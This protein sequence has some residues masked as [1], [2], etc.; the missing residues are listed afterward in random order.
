M[1]CKPNALVLFNPVFNNGPG[2]WGH[3]RAGGSLPRLSP[4]HRMTGLGACPRM[5]FRKRRWAMSKRNCR[6]IAPPE[7]GSV[8]AP[9]ARCL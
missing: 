3:T 6:V 5:N 1:S 7:P 9:G 4:A 2:Q 8:V